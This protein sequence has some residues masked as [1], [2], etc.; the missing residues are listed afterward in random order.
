MDYTTFENLFIA[1][2]TPLSI[3]FTSL[4]IGVITYEC[5]KQLFTELF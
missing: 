1:V 4:M 2:M 3:G 5:L